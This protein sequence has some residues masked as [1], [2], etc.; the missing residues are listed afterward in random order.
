MG[1]SQPKITRADHLDWCK[2]RALDLCCTGDTT[3][4]FASMVSDLNKHSETV[5]HASIGI[6]MILQIAGHLGTPERMA[7]FIGDFN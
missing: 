3:Q 1:S 6:G 7:K 4:A 2:S 5:G